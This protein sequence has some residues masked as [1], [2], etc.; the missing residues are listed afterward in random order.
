MLLT[1]VTSLVLGTGGFKVLPRVTADAASTPPSSQRRDTP[2]TTNSL[3]GEI[4]FIDSTS[5]TLSVMGW[6]AVADSEALN[7]GF[8]LNL[9]QVVSTPSILT[10]DEIQ[11]FGLPAGTTDSGSGVPARNPVGA[12]VTTAHTVGLACGEFHT[13]LLKRD[14]TVL[15]RG[16][17]I[18]GQLSVPS[19]LT[20]AIAIACGSDHSLAIRRD[21][22]VVAW[23]DNR[24][25]QSTVPD[26]LKG[27]VAIAGGTAHSLALLADGH[28]VGWGDNFFHQSTP[29]E[30]LRDAT[31][32][33]AGAYHSL[34]LRRDGTVVAWGENA[35]GQCDVPEGLNS[36]VQIAAGGRFSLALLR[37]GRVVAWGASEHNQTL[38]PE[39]LTEVTSIAAGNYHALALK[40]DGSVVAWG[41]STYSSTSVPAGLSNVVAIAAGGFHSEALVQVLPVLSHFQRTSA[42]IRAAI[43][44]P[45]G[46]RYQMEASQDLRQW[47]ILR[48]GIAIPGELDVTES[49]NA[50]VPHRFFRLSPLNVLGTRSLTLPASRGSTP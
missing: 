31:A 26:A 43:N 7:A 19:D 14:G 39:N 4:E 5:V 21:H 10:L 42:G 48:E 22:T 16:W 9:N 46:T 8:S 35:A 27:A 33:A 3:T 15:A 1:L 37:S 49:F 12:D 32:I 11:K 24:F 47:T 34:A 29:P 40:R 41:D 45:A 2:L 6:G 23:G 44:L 17:N 38:I 25:G 50:D 18:V 30:T 20:N 13:V 28:V 36:V